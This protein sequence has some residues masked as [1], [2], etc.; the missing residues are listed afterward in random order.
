[1]DLQRKTGHKH[2]IG[3]PESKS[4]RGNA[5]PALFFLSLSLSLS[6]SRS[7]DLSLGL[8]RVVSAPLCQSVA[9]K[10]TRNKKEKEEN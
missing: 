3:D 8:S 9:E 6:L 5:Q 10:W 1:M 2:K 7:L 4:K